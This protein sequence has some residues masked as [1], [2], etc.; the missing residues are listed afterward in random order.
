MGWLSGFIWSYITPQTY[1]S[2]P[3]KTYLSI[4]E[5]LRALS[6]AVFN[7]WNWKQICWND[8]MKA[9]QWC[10]CQ[11]ERDWRK[12]AEQRWRIVHANFPSVGF[13]KCI[14]S[15]LILTVLISKL[16]PPLALFNL[17]SPFPFFFL[18][19]SSW[20]KCIPDLFSFISGEERDFPVLSK[21]LGYYSTWNVINTSAILAGGNT[22]EFKV[23]GFP[24]STRK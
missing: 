2:I 17:I 21:H 20:L 12:N 9:K 18:L 10:I 23:N 14:L 4:E 8:A 24:F 16:V 3:D 15:Y 7:Y 11:N 5:K 1:L 13:I 19:T 22:L 6:S